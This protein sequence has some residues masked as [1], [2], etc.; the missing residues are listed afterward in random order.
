MTKRKRECRMSMPTLA[1]C[2]LV[3]AVWLNEE[4]AGVTTATTFWSEIEA[5]RHV[6]V[7]T[8][9][10]KSTSSVTSCCQ[11]L[12]EDKMIET[13]S[14]QSLVH[15]EVFITEKA[16]LKQFIKDLAGHKNFIWFAAMNLVQVFHCQ[17][18]SNFF[19]LFLENLLGDSVPQV[20]CSLL[21]GI[22]FIAPHINNLHLLSICRRHGVYAVILGLLLVKLVLSC[23]MFA[24]GPNH[25]WLLGLFI[26]SNHVLTE[27]TCTLLALVISDLVDKDFVIHRCKQAVSTLMFGTAA[28]VSNPGQTLAPL[29]GAWPLSI[30]TVHNVFDSGNTGISLKKDLSGLSLDQQQSYCLVM[31][32]LLVLMPI[33]CTTHQLM[34]WSRFNP[35]G[36]RLRMVK[37]PRKGAAYLAVWCCMSAWRHAILHH[38]QRLPKQ[39]ILHH[40]SLSWLI[41]I[42]DC[43]F[44]TLWCIYLDV[45][46]TVILLHNLFS[47]IALYLIN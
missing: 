44:F 47:H 7:A 33:V 25:M 18:N 1:S 16:A 24:V 29:I 32:H 35:K 45:A 2:P 10:P 39:A 40:A 26:A 14:S 46:C 9:T 13:S 3:R 19:P 30:Q 8:R 43:I 4:P 23:I 41:Q 12:K 28:V 22:S 36:E 42:S 21:L 20:V 27:S 38:I 31:F 37:S 5:V 11:S 34:G 6:S 15:V 17:F